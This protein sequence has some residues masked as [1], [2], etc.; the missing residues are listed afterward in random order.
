MGDSELPVTVALTTIFVY[1]HIKCHIKHS[2]VSSDRLATRLR[3]CIIG[4]LPLYKTAAANRNPWDERLFDQA[5]RANL[6]KTTKK[7]SQTSKLG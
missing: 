7:T 2:T 3:E 5:H 6:K 4:M 1:F